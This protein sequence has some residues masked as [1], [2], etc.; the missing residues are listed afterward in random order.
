MACTPSTARAC[1]TAGARPWRLL[2]SWPCSARW[3]EC[4]GE[5]TPACLPS[6]WNIGRHS[7]QP[8]AW[9]RSVAQP[10][11]HPPICA[12]LP[13]CSI[14]GVIIVCLVVPL[15][16]YF[17]YQIIKNKSKNGPNVTERWSIIQEILPAMKL[18]K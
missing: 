17:G 15:Q 9:H 16:Y 3:S 12:P 11:I 5:R 4:T 14:G 7:D 13:L 1:I 6:L 18:V 10:F 2:P 8:F